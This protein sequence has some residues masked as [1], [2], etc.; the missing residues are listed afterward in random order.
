MSPNADV[1]AMS[2][3]AALISSIEIG[4][5]VL[6]QDFLV[7]EWNQFMENHTA[8]GV[9]EIRNQSLFTHIQEIDADW[10]KNKCKPVFELQ[11]PVYIIWEQRQFLFKMHSARPISSPSEFMYQNIEILPIVNPDSGEVEKAC[12]LVYDATDQA[13]GKLRIEGLNKKLELISRVDGLTGLNNRRYWQERF[14]LEYKLAFRTNKAACV[15]ILDI[16]HFKNVNDTYGHQAGDAVIKE[17]A[18]IVKA[19]TRETDIS[20]RYGGEEFV[21][22]LPETTAKNAM[23]VAER[24]RNATEACAIDHDGLDISVTISIG[25]AQFSAE[26]LTAMQWLEAADGALYEAKQKGR[27][28]TVIATPP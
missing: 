15:I 27:N 23:V 14:E 2:W 8:I 5:V 11:I 10:F 17:V 13:T 24:I 19:S 20:G 18:S 1:K 12:L 26:Y 4:V 28:Q 22:I 6:N 25:I 21:A 3:Q 7:E 9:T 16:D